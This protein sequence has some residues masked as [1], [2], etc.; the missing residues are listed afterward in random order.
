M[1]TVRLE[2]KQFDDVLK[3]VEDACKTGNAT[4]TTISFDSANSL[5]KIISPVKQEILHALAGSG[6]MGV[7]ELARKV[8]RDASAIHRDLQVL[9][10]DRAENGKVIFPYD[11]V[12]VDF[13][14]S[15]AA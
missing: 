6:V 4:E 11:D 14:L 3:E 1:K 8:G 13:R 9:I 12:H 10:V 15:G 7:R 5:W 2:V